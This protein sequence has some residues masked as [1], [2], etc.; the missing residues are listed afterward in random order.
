MN[1]HETAERVIS[2]HAVVPLPEKQAYARRA[3]RLVG[4]QIQAHRLHSATERKTPV[5]HLVDIGEPSTG[6]A[7]R[8]DDALTSRRLNVEE[9]Q[10]LSLRR[11]TAFGHHSERLARYE[12]SRVRREVVLGYVIAFGMVHDDLAAVR[13][14]HPEIGY[15]NV[16]Q[17]RRVFLT[18]LREVQYPLDGME[19]RIAFHAT[20]HFQAGRAVGVSVKILDTIGIVAFELRRRITPARQQCRRVLSPVDERERRNLSFAESGLDPAGDVD[21]IVAHPDRNLSPC[22]DGSQCQQH[23]AEKG[24]EKRFHQSVLFKLLVEF[25]YSERELRKTDEA[26]GIVSC[27]LHAV[28]RAIPPVRIRF[29]GPGFGKTRKRQCPTRKVYRSPVPSLYITAAS[30]ASIRMWIT[31]IWIS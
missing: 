5:A 19:R 28:I 17:N 11:A 25:Q 21:G 4:M 30:S 12:R 18:G 20:F 13:I 27:G 24:S 8:H 31:L 3:D 23:E 1:P 29:A 6:P 26:A 9:R 22:K 15:A 16:L 2:Y 10:E 7:D 14:G